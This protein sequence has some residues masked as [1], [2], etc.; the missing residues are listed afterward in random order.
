MVIFRC[1]VTG[2]EGE[3]TSVRR[4]VIRSLKIIPGVLLEVPDWMRTCV[5]EEA[6]EV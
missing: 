5:Y 6:Y 2:E 4:E 3:S 1:G